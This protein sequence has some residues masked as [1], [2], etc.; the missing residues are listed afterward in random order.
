MKL[1][2]ALLGALL[3][4]CATIVP[5]ND[6]SYDVVTRAPHIAGGFAKALQLASVAA[7]KQCGAAGYTEVS[8]TEGYAPTN[9]WSVV[10]LEFRC[11]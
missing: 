5:M 1:A 6:N 2:A 10:D 9:D 7:H 3:V 8:K 4:G 11:N